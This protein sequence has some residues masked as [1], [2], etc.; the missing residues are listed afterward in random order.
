MDSVSVVIPTWNRAHTIGAAIGSV[1]KQTHAVQEILVCDDGSTD[2]TR[3]VVAAIGDDR[4][5]FIDGPR[6]GRPAVPRNRGI[7]AAQGEWIAFLDSDDQWLPAK[8]HTQFG[9]M[10]QTGAAAS[11]TNAL[12]F[13]PGEGEKGA[14]LPTVRPS[15]D[16]AVLLQ[17]NFVIC[18][19]ALVRKDVVQQA[20]GF[21]EGEELRAIED[22]ALWLRV[23]TQTEFAYCD[24]P[25]TVYR[26]D[27]GNSI[28]SGTK[29]FEQKENVMKDLYAWNARAGNAAH[30]QL[31]RKAYRNAMKRN[32]RS[33]WERMKIK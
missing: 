4:I 25:L 32:G 21:P 22:Y 27:P 24:A 14:Y 33:F 2:S 13:V 7:H 30:Q 23:A 1:L 3:E 5:R 9:R 15:F 8:L 12:R 20:G 29:E 10:K 26:D 28:R 31:I 16:L 17:T 19:S 18:S 11:S 6:A